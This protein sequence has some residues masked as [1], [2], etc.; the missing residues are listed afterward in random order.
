MDQHMLSAAHRL[1]LESASPIPDIATLN[2]AVAEA[3]SALATFRSNQQVHLLHVFIKGPSFF[4]MALGHRLNALG[5]VQLY[6]W[7]GSA[8]LPTVKVLT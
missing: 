1:Y 3:K 7:V 6:D 5:E 8:Y 2:T 4:A